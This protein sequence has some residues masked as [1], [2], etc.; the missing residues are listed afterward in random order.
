MP[1][2]LASGAIQSPAQS[3]QTAT[4]PGSAETEQLE[5]PG[6]RTAC[7]R[8]EAGSGERML[9]Q[10][11]QRYRRQ[12]LGD[13]SHQKAEKDGGRRLRDRLARAVIGDHAVAQQLG[14]HP[15]GKLAI[16]RDQRGPRSEPFERLAQHQRDR[17]CFFVLVG[18]V[19]RAQASQREWLGRPPSPERGRWQKRLPQ[20]GDPAFRH[21]LKFHAARPKGPEPNVP[22]RRAQVSQQPVHP[23]LRVPRIQGVPGR[24][25]EVESSPGR[26]TSPF[27]RCATTLS[28]RATAGMPPVAPAT[29]TGSAGGACSQARAWASS[30]ATRLAA[31]FIRP[32]SDSQAGQVVVTICRKSSVC[33]Q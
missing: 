16:R 26:T 4:R 7:G 24:V 8:G 17:G 2:R 25:V 31:E 32:C 6:R 18:G 19:E 3:G 1:V 23:R 11:E 15:T 20:Q 12:I 14:G 29:S 9:E 28:N 27:G 30:S 21:A 22:R 13:R 33:F 5:F 10:R